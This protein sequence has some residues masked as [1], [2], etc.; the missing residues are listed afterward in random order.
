MRVQTATA[1]A[2]RTTRRRTTHDAR[3]TTHDARRGGAAARVPRVPRLCG[4]A[5]RVGVAHGRVG[6]RE[7]CEEPTAS[8]RLRS[9]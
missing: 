6:K 8:L 3:R 1:T 5:A 4:R 2:R 7:C 9:K